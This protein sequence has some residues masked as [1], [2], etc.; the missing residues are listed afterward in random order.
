MIGAGSA[1][2]E[3]YNIESTTT[4]DISIN[5]ANSLIVDYMGWVSASSLVGETAQLIL[6]G[7]NKAISLTSTNTVFTSYANS[8]TYP[9][10]TGA[11]I[12]II[13]DTS[14]TTVSLYEC[15]VIVAFKPN[16]LGVVGNYA[17]YIKVGNN[18][19]RSERAK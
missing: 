1:V 10:G 18:E 7:V 4:G 2:T 14:L 11:D 15:G 16:T 3:E 17:P 13:T 5:S 9:A 6:N 19:S 8:H 12:G